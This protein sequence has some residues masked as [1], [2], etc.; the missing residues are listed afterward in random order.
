MILFCDTSALIKLLISE[1]GS[2]RMHQAS[3]EAESLAV[4]R[5]TWAEAMAGLARRQ[6]EH[7]QDTEALEQARQQLI[8]SWEHC[9]IVE[10]TQRLVETAGRFADGF[11]LRGYDSVQLAAAHELHRSSD[12]PVTFACFDRRLRQAAALM[13]LDVLA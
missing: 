3:L 1:P 8:V 10:V 12:Q 2:D 6:R 5:L 4:C 13:R 11:A 7:P 9:T